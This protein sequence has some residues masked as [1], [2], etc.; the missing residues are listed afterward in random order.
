MV[1]NETE[2]LTNEGQRFEAGLIAGVD[3]FYPT[4]H[5]LDVDR[6]RTLINEWKKDLTQLIPWLDWSVWV[7]CR[8]ACGDKVNQSRHVIPCGMADDCDFRW[9]CATCLL[10][11]SGFSRLGSCWIRIIPALLR[12]RS[13]TPPKENGRD[14]NQ[15]ASDGWSRTVSRTRF[16]YM[17]VCFR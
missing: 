14:H 7:K 16:S 4:D 17:L 15:S 10:S 6:I 9:R 8:P 13:L 2:S 11:H 12:P 3:P 5:P 1:E